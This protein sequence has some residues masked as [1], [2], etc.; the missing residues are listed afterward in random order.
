VDGDTL[1]AEQERMRA[2]NQNSEIRPC[3]CFSHSGVEFE[4]HFSVQEVAEMWGLGVD[5][6][7]ELFIDE[8]DVIQIGNRERRGCRGY[9]TL[10]VPASVVRRVHARLRAKA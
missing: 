1:Q 7:R 3:H 2:R 6:I 9:I 8:P 4:R 5:K 10:R